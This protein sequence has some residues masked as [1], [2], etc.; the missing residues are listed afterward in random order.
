[1]EKKEQE[2]PS[3]KMILYGILIGLAIIFGFCPLLAWLLMVGWIP[4]SFS[5]FIF[6][7]LPSLI[8]LIIGIIGVLKERNKKTE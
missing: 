8:C 5:F 6:P 3:D 1:M 2:P 7:I 4:W